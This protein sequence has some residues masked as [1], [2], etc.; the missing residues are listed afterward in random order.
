MDSKKS[1]WQNKKSSEPLRQPKSLTQ[2]QN[3]AV[4]DT[5]T[6]VQNNVE[7]R[8]PTMEELVANSSLKADAPE[9]I[10]RFADARDTKQSVSSLTSRIQ[11][12]LKI[13]RSESE[14]SPTEK[15]ENDSPYNTDFVESDI[16]RIRQIINTLTKDPGQFDNL[17]QIFMDTVLPYL[18]DII[19]LSDIVQIVVNEVIFFRFN[20]IEIRLTSKNITYKINP[21]NYEKEYKISYI[22]F[23][24]L[25]VLYI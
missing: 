4:V 6:K 20:D 23:I 25:I 15:V 2:K 11:N 17:L 8:Y 16:K 24:V 18:E 10:P 12:R 22:L 13:C 21:T 14:C 9:F 5:S 1:L 3:E 19:L 7:K